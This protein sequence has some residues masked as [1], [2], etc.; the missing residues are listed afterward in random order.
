MEGLGCV[1]MENK[2]VIAF[3]YKKLKPHEQNYPTH[4]LEL[5]AVVFA[6]KKWRY[7]LYG[8]TH[9]IYG[10]L[11]FAVHLNH[12]IGDAIGLVQFLNAVS[13]I[14]KYP[15]STPSPLLVWQRELLS[16]RNPP[17]VTCVHNE[18]EVE[19]NSNSCAKLT[20]LDPAANLPRKGFFFRPQEIKAIKKYLAP[21]I[22][23]TSRFDLGAAFLWRSRSIALQ[24]DL[25][26]IVS[27]AC[28][29]AALIRNSSGYHGNG[30]VTL[31][32]VLKVEKLCNNPLGYALGL[33][34]KAKEQ[35][36]E[37]FI[38]SAIDYSALDGKPGQGEDGFVMPLCLPF[39]AMDKFQEEM[40]KMI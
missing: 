10:G 14:A 33:V 5:A 34:K 39:A 32:T 37:D 6:L 18:Y 8:V 7:Y 29:T 22:C 19:K 36:T 9:L 17:C 21:K 11:V 30:F 20:I 27:L 25:E 16:A 24:L 2:N 40:E 23:Y 35:V 1:L 13:Q 3:D 4:D 38:K 28:V 31:A 26:E 12:L 15:S